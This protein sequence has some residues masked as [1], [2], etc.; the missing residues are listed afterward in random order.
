VVIIDTS[1]WVEML[2]SAGRADVRD[3]V[4][5]HLIAGVACTVPVIRLELWNG[6][7]GDREKRALREFDETLPELEM[8]AEV[9]GEARELA[10][11][12]RSAG[13]ILP[14]TDILIAACARHHGATIEAVDLHFAELEKL[15]S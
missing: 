1:A 13:L 7:R 11:L 12:A 2:R 9:W 4:N 3:R 15:R 5:A 6:A 10:R 8:N 14:A